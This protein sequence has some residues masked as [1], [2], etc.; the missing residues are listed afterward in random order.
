MGHASSPIADIVAPY[1]DRPKGGQ[2]NLHARCPFHEDSRP[3]FSINVENGLWIC[4]GCKLKGGLTTFFQYMG[5]SRNKIDTLIDPVRELLQQY[6]K[7][8]RRRNRNRF[9]DGDPFEGEQLLKESLLGLF[10]FAPL[11]LIDKGFDPKIIRSLDIGYDR[12]KDRI[13]FPIRD[14][15]G[16]LVGVSGRSVI[17]DEPRYKVYRGGFL[18]DE[19][20]KHEGDFGSE[21]DELY[22]GY[23]INPRNYLWNAHR[24]YPSILS[25]E[26]DEPIF[27]MEGYKA[28]VW[29]IQH[30]YPNTVATMGSYMSKVQ[31]DI[32]A[33]LSGTK[34]LFYDNDHSGISGAV[35]VGEWLNK[36]GPVEVV[37]LYDWAKQADDLNE[38]GL[39]EVIE[40]RERFRKWK[41][42]AEALEQQVVLDVR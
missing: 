7:K 16:N 20:T 19:G 32:L 12:R 4:G 3:S 29:M 38:K 34:V 14:L 21:F 22:K 33:R 18:D 9:K 24:V 17:D 40:G 30:G 31:R 42:K 28:A 25:N 39:K 23:Q 5:L 2:R 26:E 8:E 27:I 1:L 36:I 13:I 6:R 41:R 11:D 37:Q 35:R 10:D 15:Y